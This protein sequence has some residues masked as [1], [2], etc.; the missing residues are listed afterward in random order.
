MMPNYRA[1]N[2]LW[3]GYP[4]EEMPKSMILESIETARRSAKAARE[5]GFDYVEVGGFAHGSAIAS[6]FVSQRKSPDGRIWRVA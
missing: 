1:S 5:F 2:G 6:F 3:D 4:C